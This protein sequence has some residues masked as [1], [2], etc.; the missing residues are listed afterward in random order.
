MTFDPKYDI[1]GPDE[2]GTY[3]IHPGPNEHPVD[4]ARAQQYA[5]DFDLKGE[6]NANLLLRID[7][8]IPRRLARV[9]TR[10]RNYGMT[11]VGTDIYTL[12]T[13]ADEGEAACTG[14][15]KSATDHG[16]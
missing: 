15:E 3:L 2:N 9:A 12:E 11:F 10:L 4:L 1:G 13:L 5:A 8:A 16:V 7:A 6:R 14:L